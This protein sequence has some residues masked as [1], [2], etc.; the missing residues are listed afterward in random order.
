MI[1]YPKC[2]LH[3]HSD[4]CDGADSPQQI[5]EEALRQG[6]EILGFS[7]HSYT[8]FDPHSCMSVEGTDRYK[9]EIARL[10]ERYGDRIRILCGLEQD[11][12]SDQP[13]EGHDYVIGSVHYVRKNGTYHSVDYKADQVRTFIRTDFE[14][15]VYKYTKAYYETLAQVVEKTGCQI[16][17]HFDLVE[18]FNRGGMLFSNEDYRYRRPMLDALD[19]L[20]KKD[21]IF[22]INTGVIARGHRDLPYPSPYV[23]R[24]IAE[25]R[26]RVILSSD[27]HKKEA[28]TFAFSDAVQYAKSCGIG[29]L[30]VPARHGWELR[31]IG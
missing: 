18:K 27:A 16:V 4:L 15:D 28:L 29:A 2:N 26:G 21:V 20:L 17:G 1:Y 24:R 22:E 6:M 23:L 9:S 19:V 5:V 12:Y 30:T 31:S 14:D 7:G 8:S 3:T 10:K 11:F 13:A 25:K